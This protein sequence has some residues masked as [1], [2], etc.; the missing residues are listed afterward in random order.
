MFRHGRSAR[1]LAELLHPHPA[2]TE[3]VQDCVRMLLGT[4]IYK[5][6]VFKSALRLSRIGYGAGVTR[7][8]LRAV[9]PG[10]GVSA[11]DAPEMPEQSA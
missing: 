9:S 11:S 4:S 5:P 10:G 6:S 8:T 1:E 2:V 3:G 7:E